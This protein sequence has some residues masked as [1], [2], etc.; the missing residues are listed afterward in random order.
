MDRSAALIDSV[1]DAVFVLDAAGRLVETNPAALEL[2]GAKSIDQ[3]PDTPEQFILRYLIRNPAGS[4]LVPAQLVGMRALAGERVTNSESLLRTVHG[5]ELYVSSSAAPTRDQEGRIV[6][7][8]V[9]CRDI[10]G[11]RQREKD[12]QALLRLSRALAESMDPGHLLDTVLNEVGGVLGPGPT[13]VFLA[14][15]EQRGVGLRAHRYCSASQVAEASFFPLDGDFPAARVLRTGQAEVCYEPP[16]VTLPLFARGHPVG[17]IH[18]EPLLGDELMTRD[19]AVF[20]SM[21][22]QIAMA[23]QNAELFARVQEERLRLKAV[24]DSLPEAVLLTDRTGR[25]MASNQAAE[26]LCGSPIPVGF[27]LDREDRKLLDFYHPTG[28]RC[29]VGRWPL[30]RALRTGEPC[31]GEEMLVQHPGGHR[32]PILMNAAP[33]RGSDGN[34]D[35]AVA[36]FQSIS[37]LKEVE[38]LKDDFISIAAHEL[39]TPVTSIKGFAQLLYRRFRLETPGAVGTEEIRGLEV[40]IQQAERL[41]RLTGTILDVSRLDLGSMQL[42]MEGLD[43]GALVQEVTGRMQITTD[44]HTITVHYRGRGESLAVL[45]DAGRLEQVLGNLVAN[46]VKYSPGGGEVRV[47]IGREG[48]QVVV[49]VQ[50]QGIGIPAEQQGLIFGRFYRA[51]NVSQPGFSGLGLGLYLASEILARH[52]GRIWV[53]SQPGAGST[54]YFSLPALPDEDRE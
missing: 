35:G 4:L 45:G 11:R 33:L 34:V 25:L 15:P 3:I 42:Q 23:L 27:S 12:L 44:R 14:E 50:D 22:D 37:A 31:T 5:R 8:V 38:R 19:L 24:I 43:L 36:V 6:G 40:I 13:M 7:A 53:D 29:P 26:E 52:G 51:K 2:T 46:A 16:I 41:A 28:E 48:D 21:A 30:V 9:V 32:I 47:E 54:F 39:R 18:C 20:S 17:V 1:A 49:A 10:T